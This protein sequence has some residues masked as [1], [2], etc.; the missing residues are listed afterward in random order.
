MSQ[1]QAQATAP[2]ESSAPGDRAAGHPGTLIG[3]DD[4]EP[5]RWASVDEQ[6]ADA[7][8]WQTLR[9]LPATAAIIVRLSWATAPRLTLLAGVVQLLS[10]CTTAF[11]LFATANALTVL[12]ESGPTPQRVIDS[13]PAIAVVVASFALRGLLDT[14]VS[15]VQG[16]L[17][18]RVRHAAQDEI[19]TAVAGVALIT[20]EDADFREL[21]RQGGYHGVLATENSVRNIAEVT[22]SLVSLTAAVVTTGLLSPW[23]VPVLLLATAADAWAAMTSAK[24]GYRSFLSMVSRRMRLHVVE[25]LLV[26]RDVAAERTALTLHDVLLTEHRRVATDVTN[27]AIRLEHRKSLVRLLGRTLSG[28]GT[29]LAYIVLGILLYLTVMP[30]GLAGAA[31]MAM[32]TATSALTSTMVAINRLYEHS[33]YLRF[34][35]KLL[36]EARGHHPPVSEITAPRDPETI[37]LD[38]VSFTYPGQDQPALHNINLTLRRGEVIALVGENGSGKTTLGKILTGLYPPTHGTVWWDD[39][40]LATADTRSVYEQ[41]AV[42]AQEPARWPMIAGTNIRIGRLDCATHDA[43]WHAA[44]S[45]SGADEVLNAL[46]HGEKTVV[47]K[48]FRQGQDLSGG[49]WQR[50]GVAR[51]IYRDAAILVADEPTAALDAKAEAR[52]FAGLQHA[53]NISRSANSDRATR[54]TVL[55]THRLANVS[56]ADRILVLDQGRI[57]ESGTHQELMALG[58]HGHYHQLYSLQAQAY[59]NAADTL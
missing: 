35:E 39:V 37:R 12:L 47:S 1:Q 56:R 59:R 38:N 22:S 26:A 46:P 58:S 15:A 30:L 48:Q 43:A 11:G 32:R 8:L 52:V 23:L 14:A 5:P 55:V 13:L 3:V 16:T 42:I 33:F 31:V 18:P 9:E 28:T 53:T 10:G 24:L 20:W 25:N 40:D 7:S 49:Q 41:I 29:G 6:V 2:T 44:V 27:E 50:I 17:T 34:Y 21:A 19:N 57:V 4:L 54:T 51:G 45:K 36:H